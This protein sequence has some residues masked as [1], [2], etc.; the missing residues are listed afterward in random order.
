MR[1]LK[2]TSASLS[3]VGRKR[4]NNEDYLKYFEPDIPQEVSQ[5]GNLYIVADGVGGAAKGERASEFASETVLYEYYQQPELPPEERLRMLMREAGNR[6]FHYADGESFGRM[7]TTMVAAVIR[8]DRLLVAHVGDSRAYLIRNRQVTQLTRDHSLVGELIRDGTMSEEESLTSKVKN[9]LTRSL[10]G[11]EDVIVDVSDEIDLLPG[12]RLLLCTDGLTRYALPADILARVLV[13]SP[14]QVVQ[15][16]IDFANQQGGAD[17][18]TA[19][20]IAVHEKAEKVNWAAATNQVRKPPA[21]WEQ[22]TDPN[23]TTQYPRR[24]LR[25]TRNTYP[26]WLPLAAVGVLIAIG[27]FVLGAIWVTS[28]FIRPNQKPT[29]QVIILPPNPSEIPGQSSPLPQPQEAIPTGLQN[30]TVL[31]ADPNGL[32]PTV[33]PSAP[34]AT[35]TPIQ[36]QPN[37][38]Y[39]VKNG[40]MLSRYDLDWKIDLDNISCQP[41]TLNCADGLFI[42]NQTSLQAGMKLIFKNLAP[43]KCIEIGGTP[44]PP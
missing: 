33:D 39:L 43:E 32:P 35:F 29:Q 12:D 36:I 21:I 25:R 23:A 31:T 41:G 16:L 28:L 6:I 8:D 2:V 40:D 38:L 14:A 15:S 7:A 4:H 34:L 24:S 3:N 42:P 37:C 18:V 20:V 17:N 9:S 10:G 19:I 30:Q 1:N 27:V 22:E 44:N 26:I 13:G 11:E 5:S